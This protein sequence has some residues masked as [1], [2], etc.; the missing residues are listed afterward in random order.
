MRGE[1]LTHA[2]GRTATH[3]GDRRDRGYASRFC[4]DQVTKTA[5]RRRQKEG[6][7]DNTRTRSHFGAGIVTA[8]DYLYIPVNL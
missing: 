8:S 4:R 1:V 3:R 6:K 2:D 7:E 5:Q